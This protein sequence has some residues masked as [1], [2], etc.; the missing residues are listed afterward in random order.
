MYIEGSFTWNRL[1][2]KQIK[3]GWLHK[4][5]MSSQTWMWC[6]SLVYW[7]HLESCIAFKSTIIMN[8]VPAAEAWHVLHLSI[9]LS[10]FDVWTHFVHLGTLMWTHCYECALV[11]ISWMGY[12]HCAMYQAYSSTSYLCTHLVHLCTLLFHVNALLW[13]FISL[14]FVNGLMLSCNS[15]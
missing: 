3:C 9:W 10:T 11:F 2:W 1:Y 15:N 14:C 6:L 8:Y 5:T 13:M 4:R 7:M 12:C